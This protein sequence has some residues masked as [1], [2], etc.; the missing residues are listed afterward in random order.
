MSELAPC[1]PEDAARRVEKALEAA[2]RTGVLDRASVEALD[3]L[4]HALTFTHNPNGLE[5][6]R[7]G[8][9]R[10]TVGR[11]ARRA[12]VTMFE[13]LNAAV[14]RGQSEAVFE[15]CDCLEEFMTAGAAPRERVGAYAGNPPAAAPPAG[16]D[17]L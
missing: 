11:E 17:A 1:D 3:V 7:E 16:V 9:K 12:L 5:L 10:R 4:Y 2:P 14:E 8:L 15:I 6:W 13:Y